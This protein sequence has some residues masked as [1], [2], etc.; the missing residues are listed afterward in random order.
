MLNFVGL[1]TI[2][3]SIR[4]YGYRPETF[5]YIEG[6]FL[7]RGNRYRF[8]VR[9]GKHRAALLTY[10]GQ[11]TITVRVRPTWPRVIG[12]QTINDWPLVR[13]GQISPMLADKILARYFDEA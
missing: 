7:Q 11:E 1:W 8:F 6:H 9:G 2:A 4:K 3:S 5:G 10:H 13:S 12:D